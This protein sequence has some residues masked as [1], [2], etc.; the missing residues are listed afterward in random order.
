MNRP[1]TQAFFRC[2][3]CHAQ[4][5]LHV[6]LREYEP[7]GYACD[8]CGE[9]VWVNLDDLCDAGGKRLI[10]HRPFEGRSRDA[11]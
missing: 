6:A 1:K 3:R 2:T 10:S 7:A 4:T 5:V 8:S 11:E 9:T